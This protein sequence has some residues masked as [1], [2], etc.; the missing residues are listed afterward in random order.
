MEV[1]GTAVIAIR[2]FVKN[3]YPSD[4]KKWL[5]AMNNDSREIYG[6]TIDSTKWYL[7]ETAALE[8][9]KKIGDLFFGGNH[10]SGARESG[11]YSAQK[12]LTGIYKIFVKAASPAYIVQRA[13]RVFATYYQPCE[14]R[15]VNATADSCMIEISKM[16]KRYDII[17]N[18]IAGWI[19]TALEIS[20]AKEIKVLVSS[21]PEDDSIRE[22][23]VSWK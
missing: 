17:D 18:R 13:S 4:Y 21:K 6:G 22:I 15:V 16:D 9:T 10:I 2:D 8:P 7:V 12:A 19:E 11:K 1:K 23:N 3:N 20:G 14:M 5:D